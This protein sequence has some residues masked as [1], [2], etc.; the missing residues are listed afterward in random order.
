[1][2]APDMSE[3]RAEGVRMAGSSKRRMMVDDRAWARNGH[4]E[5]V[6]TL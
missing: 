3:D 6:T 4:V 1:M 5:A 2:A